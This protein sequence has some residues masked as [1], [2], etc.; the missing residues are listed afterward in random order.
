MASKKMILLKKIKDHL[1]NSPSGLLRKQKEFIEI[2]HDEVLAKEEELSGKDKQIKLLS[3]TCKELFE[4]VEGLCAHIKEKEEELDA[5]NEELNGKN[6]EINA[7]NEELDS[8]NEEI[9]AKNGELDAKN[10]ELNAKTKELGAKTEQLDAKTE[11]LNAKTEELNAKNE[12]LSKLENQYS[13]NDSDDFVISN[14]S[15]I[16]DDFDI[17][18]D[19][20]IS[21]D[22]DI[23]NRIGGMEEIL[24][25]FR[26]LGQQIF[27]EL[28]AK[29]EKLDAKTEEL[30]AKTEELD[31]KNDK[32]SKLENQYSM[33][34]SDDFDIANDSDISDDF[35]ISEDYDIKN[36]IGGMEEILIRFPHLGQKI[37]DLLESKS[38]TR[39]TEVS[40]GW[41]NFIMN[42]NNP[43]LRMIQ[44]YTNCSKATL[45]KILQHRELEELRYEVHIIYKICNFEEP[46][47]QAAKGYLDVFKLITDNMKDKNPRRDV[48]GKTPLHFA[49]I[50]GHLE[51]CQFIIEHIST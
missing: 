45:K 27:E 32:L 7:I 40:M 44:D 26:H 23:N 3:D 4:M 46:I 37:F 30:N 16:S 15:D 49:T 17:S 11:Q 21:E 1:E 35:D 41:R 14:N 48:D 33:N 43:S 2:L 51:V 19:T 6:E 22:F 5:K 9:D 25:R 20:D 50:S 36:R 18:E 39:C 31:A 47:Y 29:T 10:E 8:K 13:M 42:E 12:E 24:L 34:D 38:L 28:D